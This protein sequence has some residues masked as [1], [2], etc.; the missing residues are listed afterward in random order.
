MFA[1]D[2]FLNYENIPIVQIHSIPVEDCLFWKST[3]DKAIPI[4]K[5]VS[6][7]DA[8]K[9]TENNLQPLGP[10]V[11]NNINLPSWHGTQFLFALKGWYPIKYV[12]GPF[13]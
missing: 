11:Y 4:D 10:F 6:T 2:V 13:L 9:R 3:S 5:K 12:N 1:I 7:F 8:Y